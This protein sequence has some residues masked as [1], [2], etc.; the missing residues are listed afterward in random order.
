MPALDESLSADTVIDQ[1]VFAAPA[2]TM[3]VAGAE[4]E[5][6]LKLPLRKIYCRWTV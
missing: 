6:P 3:Q 1:T 2:A 5:D 4:R